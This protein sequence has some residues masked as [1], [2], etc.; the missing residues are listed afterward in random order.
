M[1]YNLQ[2]LSV[3]LVEDNFTMR[4]LLRDVLVA[5][6]ISDITSV[7]DGGRAWRVLQEFP[8]DIAIVDWNMRPVSGLQL[9]KRI[10]QAADSPNPFLPIIMLTA[11]SEQR[12]VMAGRD[13]GVTEFLVKPVTPARLYGRIAAIIE[14]NRGFIRS[15]DYFG[16]DRRRVEK[17]AIGKDRRKEN[18]V[19][20]SEL[21]SYNRG[22][23]R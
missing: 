11:Y 13:A 17:G 1:A 9:V 21:G 7:S 8:A 16:P 5:F 19:R 23:G 2:Q 22:S 14:Q 20:A 6:G 3:L 10:R 15:Q 4:S 12:R 18:P